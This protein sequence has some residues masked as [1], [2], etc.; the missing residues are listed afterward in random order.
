MIQLKTLILYCKF[1]WFQLM[2][3]SRKNDVNLQYNENFKKK[4]LQTRNSLKVNFAWQ[5]ELEEDE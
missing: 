2:S 4:N 5:I 1:V 3:S